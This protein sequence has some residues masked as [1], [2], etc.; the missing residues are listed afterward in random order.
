MHSLGYFWVLYATPL[1]YLPIFI[2]TLG[3]SIPMTLKCNLRLGVVMHPALFLLF[4]IALIIH[5]LLWFHMN[6]YIAF[7]KPVKYDIR[8]FTGIDVFKPENSSW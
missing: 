7:P 1:V 3:F 2:T 6:S 8:I 4:R 5:G